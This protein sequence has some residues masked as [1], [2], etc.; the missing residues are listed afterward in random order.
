MS[1]AILSEKHT[2]S[3]MLMVVDVHSIVVPRVGASS[4]FLCPTVP[5]TLAAMMWGWCRCLSPYPG[6]CWQG[7]GIAIWL[8]LGYVVGNK[9]W[10]L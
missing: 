6:F 3:C 5:L 7:C 4:T 10:W 2:W 9:Y 1:V 8:Q